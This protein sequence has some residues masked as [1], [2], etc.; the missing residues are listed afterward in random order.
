MVEQAGE[1]T[2]PVP[3]TGRGRRMLL[4]L[5]VTGFFLVGAWL[6]ASAAAQAQTISGTDAPPPATQSGGLLS[7]A[8]ALVGN[9]VHAVVQTVLPPAPSGPS[10]PSPA[11]S[12]PP[13]GGGVLPPLLP[14]PH[15]GSPTGSS[16][17]S[18]GGWVNVSAPVSTVSQEPA[19][20]TAHQHATSAPADVTPARAP[21][22]RS[23]SAQS[24][25]SAAAHTSR[26]ATKAP[27]TVPEPSGDD[28]RLPSAPDPAP[29][30]S[31]PTAT[32]GH[33]GSTGDRATFGSMP[34]HGRMARNP[35]TGTEHGEAVRPLGTVPG[36]PSISPD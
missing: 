1:P 18:A 24:T 34:E 25:V 13:S 6:C 21:V 23:V 7:G 11:P 27:V 8:T 31:A 17:G 15:V 14:V 16:S 36:L 33:P 10:D 29:G 32:A 12:Q 30:P 35:V 9:T 3:C 19:A 20:V 28:K 26:A 22:T 5:A 4:R 2:P